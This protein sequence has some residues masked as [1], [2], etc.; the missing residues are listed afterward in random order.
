MSSSKLAVIVFVHQRQLGVE[1]VL[2]M[3]GMIFV[4]DGSV[5]IFRENC[6]VEEG[7]FRA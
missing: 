1:F 7:A 4:G 3:D 6:P 5:D 2:R